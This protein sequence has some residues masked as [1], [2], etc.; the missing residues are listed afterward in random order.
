MLATEPLSA[1]QRELVGKL[2]AQGR[3]TKTLVQHL[4]IFSRQSKAVTREVNVH[5]LLEQAILLNEYEL[6]AGRVRL[7]PV[8]SDLPGIVRGDPQ[9][10]LQVFVNVIRNAADS[11]RQSGQPGTLRISHRCLTDRVRIEFTD[12]GVGVREPEH[13]FDP[14]Y[15]TKAVGQGAGLGLSICYGILQQHQGSISCCN[16]PGRGVTFTIEL[17]LVKIPLPEPSLSPRT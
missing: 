10:L 13:V 2:Q 15:T 14:F 9:Q 1:A 6:R 11:I 16:N 4:L 5:A 8:F 12:T 17:P 3:R 7:H